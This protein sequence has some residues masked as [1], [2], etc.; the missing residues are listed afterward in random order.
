MVLLHRLLQVRRLLLERLRSRGTL[1]SREMLSGCVVNGRGSSSASAGRQARPARDDWQITG[2]HA[3]RT[4]LLVGGRNC[5][6]AAGSELSCVDSRKSS[7]DMRVV[8]VSDIG[9]SNPRM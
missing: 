8:D 2:H 5:A 4:Q 6:H 7:S 1:R 3:R 9:E